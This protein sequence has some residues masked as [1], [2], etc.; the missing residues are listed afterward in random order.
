MK[1]LTAA[2]LLVCLLATGVFAAGNFRN[3]TYYGMAMGRNGWIS[4]SVL[5]ESGVIAD[6]QVDAPQ[7]TPGKLGQALQIV[8]KLIGLGDLESVQA[9]DAVSGATMSSEG[10]KKAVLNAL[11]SA[12][13]PWLHGKDETC[14][15]AGF[16]DMP[17]Y[18]TWAHVPIDWAV[19][20]LVTQGTG[21]GTFSPN[22]TCTRAEIVTFLWRAWGCPDPYGGESYI[23]SFVDVPKNAY[24]HDAVLW[25]F[26][27]DIA[28]GTSEI[29]FSPNRGCSRAEAVTFLWRA[30]H[31]PCMVDAATPVY[32][33]IPFT[34]VQPGDYFAEAVAWAVGTGITQ[35]VSETEFAPNQK[36]IRAQI[37]TFLYRAR[38]LDRD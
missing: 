10:I 22:K 9:V 8:E 6:V 18:G 23:E 21:K 15:S 11:Q 16:T 4:V 24:Y 34:D 12:V 25:A 28:Y 33:E 5:V 29:L 37:V 2:V 32:T 20:T 7:E 17:G 27:K 36:C 38:D 14:P 31:R 19:S 3:G 26:K 35:G 1:R 30:F 13:P